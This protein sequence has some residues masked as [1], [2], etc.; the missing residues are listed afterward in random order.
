MYERNSR[1]IK[2]SPR[3]LGNSE[4]FHKPHTSLHISC[5]LAYNEAKGTLIQLSVSGFESK[6]EQIKEFTITRRKS[7]VLCLNH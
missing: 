4:N 6:I 1:E 7:N 5:N 3:L 2:N